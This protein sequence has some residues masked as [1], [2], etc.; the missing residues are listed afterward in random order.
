MINIFIVKFPFADLIS[1]NYI[2]HHWMSCVKKGLENSN[3]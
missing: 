1:F 2:N 3:P